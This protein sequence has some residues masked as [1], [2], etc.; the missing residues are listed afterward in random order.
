M[1]LLDVLAGV[2]DE[3]DNVMVVERVLRETARAPDAHEPGC[4]QQA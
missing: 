1:R 2:M 3:A 4:A